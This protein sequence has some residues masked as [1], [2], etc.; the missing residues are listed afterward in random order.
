MFFSPNHDCFSNPTQKLL[1]KWYYGLKPT[2]EWWC[3]AFCFHVT[4]APS[5]MASMTVNVAL[6]KECIS[7]QIISVL[8]TYQSHRT[9]LTQT[10]SNKRVKSKQWSQSDA[11]Q[12]PMVEF[13]CENTHESGFPSAACRAITTEGYEQTTYM[14]ISVGGFIEHSMYITLSRGLGFCKNKNI[15]S[16]YIVFAYSTKV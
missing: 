10:G 2:G 5:K 13:W 11:T 3:S 8:S 12:R 16:T 15:S 4:K 7:A 6:K 1:T 14:T 9:V